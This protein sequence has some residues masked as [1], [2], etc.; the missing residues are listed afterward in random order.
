MGGEQRLSGDWFQFKTAVG[1]KYLLTPFG[2]SQKHPL[3]PPQRATAPE[4]SNWFGKK[5][6][7]RF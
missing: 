7:A 6:I 2:A 4:T 1:N 5:T 3:R